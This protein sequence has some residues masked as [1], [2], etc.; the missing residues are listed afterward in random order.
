MMQ[1]FSDETR[2]NPYPL[3]D[4]LRA[5]SPVL[6][7]PPPFNGWMIFDYE[8]M[9]RA[10]TD[11]ETFSNAVPGPRNWFIFIDPPRHTK[12]RG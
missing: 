3:Y 6:H 2:R 7:V 8:G 10:L 5:M 11:S 4:Q 9:K 12:L 1:I